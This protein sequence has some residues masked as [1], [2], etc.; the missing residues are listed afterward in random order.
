MIKPIHVIC[1]AIF[2][3]WLI[4]MV[5]FVVIGNLLGGDALNG[6]IQ[7]AHYYL[8]GGEEPIEVSKAVFTYSQFHATSFIIS[9]FTVIAA[10]F[11]YWL[12]GGSSGWKSVTNSIRQRPSNRFLA[13]IYDIKTIYWHTLDRVEELFW[14]IFDSWRK[15]AVEFFTKLPVQECMKRLDAATYDSYDVFSPQHAG[16]DLVTAQVIGKHFYL[17]RLHEWPIYRRGAGTFLFGKLTSTPRGT[18]VRAWYRL[19]S[20]VLLG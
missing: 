11:I 5:S 20:L 10:G 12:T 8:G 9:H 16:E 1:R 13:I 14:L 7:G 15:P 6:E 18:Y 4:N 2:V 3:F 19:H 17:F